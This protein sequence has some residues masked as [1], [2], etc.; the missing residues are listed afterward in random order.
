MARSQLLSL[1]VWYVPILQKQKTNQRGCAEPL[2][3]FLRSTKTCLMQS[4]LKEARGF[5][6][7]FYIFHSLRIEDGSPLQLGCGGVSKIII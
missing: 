7:Y 3:S 5:Q 1:V 6:N 2:P 4:T